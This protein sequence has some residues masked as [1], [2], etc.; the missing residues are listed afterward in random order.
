MAYF[1]FLIELPQGKQLP[2]RMELDNFIFTSMGFVDQLGHKVIYSI[3]DTRPL[4]RTNPKLQLLS[5]NFSC[6]PEGGL[7]PIHHLQYFDVK[8]NDYVVVDSNNPYFTELLRFFSNLINQ[9]VVKYDIINN[10]I[11]NVEI[12]I[13]HND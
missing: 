2:P 4:D 11:E 10:Q 1:G 13:Q 6:S 12:Y 9:S 5:C 3:A 7:A 8:R